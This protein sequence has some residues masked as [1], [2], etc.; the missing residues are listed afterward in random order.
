ML[1][2]RSKAANACNR[3]PLDIQA[4]PEL[5]DLAG[6]ISLFVLYEIKH[7]IILAK[8]EELQW[9]IPTWVN[10]CRCHTYCRYGLPCWHMVPI[11]GTKIVF[12]N[13][14]AF[15]RLDNWEQGLHPNI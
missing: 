11:D 10:R 9:R 7:Q 4:T 3:I 13:I 5:H 2:L 1:R 14:A 15:W 6:K 12:E 8:C